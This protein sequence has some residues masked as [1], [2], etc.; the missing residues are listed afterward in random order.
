[1]NEGETKS[2]VS[3]IGFVFIIIGVLIFALGTPLRPEWF[4]QN[5]YILNAP[6]AVLA[7]FVVIGA[8][9]LYASSRMKLSSEFN[10]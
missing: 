4:I 3:K 2:D 6:T 10:S 8:I 9:L 1:M 5:N 7:T